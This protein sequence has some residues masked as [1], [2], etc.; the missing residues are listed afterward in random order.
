MTISRC[1]WARACLLM[2][3]APV[4]AR[5]VN[6]QHLAAPTPSLALLADSRSGKRPLMLCDSPM[7][8]KLRR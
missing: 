2:K 6:L 1:N 4:G 5:S 3:A 7:V 8:G